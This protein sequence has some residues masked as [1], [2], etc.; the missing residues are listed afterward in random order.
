MASTIGYPV[1]L[2]KRIAKDKLDELERAKSL[3]RFGSEARRERERIWR[4]NEKNYMGRIHNVEPDDPTADIVSVNLTFSTINTITPFVSGGDVSFIVEPYSG[5]SSAVLARYQ[6]IYLN[7]LWRSSKLNGKKKLAAG[8]FNYLLY[9]DGYLNVAWDI[10]TDDRKDMRGETIPGSERDIVQFEIQNI[11]PWDVWIDP[12]ADS[13]DDARWV[14]VKNVVPVRD[15]KNDARFFNTSDLG[16]DERYVYADDGRLH[17]SDAEGSHSGADSYLAYF[18]FYDKVERRLITFTMQSDLPHRWIEDVTCPLVQI[19]NN[20]IPNSPYHMSDVEQVMALQA[21]LD[22]TRSQMI[23]HRRRNVAKVLYRNNVL[24]AE[25][26]DALQSSTVMQGVPVNTDED[27][28]SVVQVLEATPLG[29]DVYNVSDI[30][31]NDIFEITGVNEYLRGAIPD[32]SRTATE[33]S[34]IEGSSNVKTSNKLA[35][36]EEAARQVGQLILDI[37]SE[38]YQATDFEEASLYLTGRDAEAV[39]RA[40]GEDVYD[41]EGKPLDSKL[42]PIPSL[43]AG[44]YEV[45]VER[46]STELRSPRFKEQKFKEMFMILI[47]NAPILGQLGISLN[48]KRALELWL[49]AAGVDDIDGLFEEQALMDPNVQGLLDQFGG[50]PDQQQA[51]QATIPG[52]FQQPGEPNSFAIN[53]PQQNIDENNSNIIAP[54][55]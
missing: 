54:P 9:G 30:I 26:L 18:D 5:D 16:P 2:T 43:F 55:M 21:E 1:K 13:L 24:D 15:F 7:R 14:I 12:L 40:S 48:Y 35:Q 32:A 46:G 44:T 47:Q 17:L 28:G 36:V 10:V 22:K 8:A 25:G 53:P 37:A 29:A 33:A 38:A 51:D 6:T 31:R 20:K 23:T 42:R 34:I 52:L 4:S 11:S 19:G 49:E 3:Y 27:F 50:Q 39:L 45:F 41:E